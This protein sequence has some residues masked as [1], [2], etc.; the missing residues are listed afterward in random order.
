M[1][2]SIAVLC[3]LLMAAASAVG[4]S[5][6]LNSRIPALESLTV[7][8]GRVLQP[9]RPCRGAR[10]QTFDLILLVGE[11][12][13]TLVL[14]CDERL[15]SAAVGGAQVA[16][17]L[18]AEESGPP[19]W[20]AWVAN[21]DGKEV[22][23]YHSKRPWPLLEQNIV[24]FAVHAICCLA[25]LASAAALLWVA[26]QW[27]RGRFLW[28]RGI[29]HLGPGAR[30]RYARNRAGLSVIAA[31]WSIAGAVVILQLGYPIS[32][33][34]EVLSGAAVIVVCGFHLVDSKYRIKRR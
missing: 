2:R 14:S 5:V 7:V 30:L 18:Q 13:R 10:Y 33:W 25:T 12:Y 27:W 11:Q 28:L 26:L 9:A 21:V 3:A 4:L 6:W 16:L 17:R 23:P 22:V 15:R 32:A 1:R 8:E 31:V 34:P 29:E 20:R 19:R 24:F